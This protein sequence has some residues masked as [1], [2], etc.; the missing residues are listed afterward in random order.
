[1]STFL[2]RKIKIAKVTS[3]NCETWKT[4]TLDRSQNSELKKSR[5]FFSSLPAQTRVY[6][7][8]LPGH[9]QNSDLGLYEK[10]TQVAGSQK[11]WLQWVFLNQALVSLEEFSV[12]MV[13]RFLDTPIASNRAFLLLLVRSNFWMVETTATA[14][15]N[16][17]FEAMSREPQ[18]TNAYKVHMNPIRREECWDQLPNF[19]MQI[20]IFY[21]NKVFLFNQ[22]C[23]KDQILKWYQYYLIAAMIDYLII[24]SAFLFWRQWILDSKLSKFPS[25]WPP[26]V[27]KHQASSKTPGALDLLE[28]AP[29][30]QKPSTPV[31]ET[32]GPTSETFRNKS[33]RMMMTAF[34]VTQAAT[35]KFSQTVSQAAEAVKIS[36]ACPFKTSMFNPFFRTSIQQMSRFRESVTRPARLQKGWRAEP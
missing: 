35:W 20:R 31:E 26:Q 24:Y 12:Q 6:W 11:V 17:S 3:E 8:L 13:K 1:M 4:I 21:P 15:A 5:S 23:S 16:I 10:I 33:L 18:E 7:C 19:Q 28:S 9:K 25:T 2:K 34:T 29:S 27:I 22:Y 36:T 14:S 32:A 30:P